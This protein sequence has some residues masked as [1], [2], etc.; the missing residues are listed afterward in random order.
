LHQFKYDQEH[1]MVIRS[2]YQSFLV[3]KSQ[4]A[5]G[6]GIDNPDLPSWMFDYQSS[7]TAWALRMGRAA[8]FADCGMGKTPMQ[9]V[10]ADNVARSTNKPVLIL[11]PIA[12]GAQTIAEA[13]KFGIEA[14]RS[15]GIAHSGINVTNY[16]KLHKFNASDFSGV[17]CDESSILKQ[18]DGAT[19]TRVTE[20]MR[21]LPFRLLCTATAAPND[22]IELGT[23]SEALG[24]LGHI[25]M[26]N[27][28][29]KNARNT[30][31]TKRNWDTGALWRLKA[32]AETPF[33]QW[34]ASWARALRKPSDLGFSD[35]GFDLPPLVEKEHIVASIKP[36]NGMLFALPANG[37]KEQ[38][39]ERRNTIIERCGRAAD[40]INA[41]SEPAVAWC[42]LNDEGDLLEK[43]INGC[44]QISGADSD[45]EKEEKFAAFQSGKVRALVIKPII[46]AWGLNW[47]HCNHMTVF[48]GYS[49]EQY[50][51]GIRRCWR[52]GQKRS[53][54]VDH[55]L[56]DGET[57]VIASRK[58]KSEKTDK[59]FAELVRHM[60]D[61]LAV[62]S[63]R[64]G[65][66]K[67]EVP[68]WL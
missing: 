15:D 52:F 5:G 14:R 66:K 42:N 23:S 12:V 56:S 34:V 50:Y 32:H 53:V 29:F 22:F 41:T 33:W 31:D 47:Q 64:Y 36:R 17:V 38:R 4:V 65:E 9:L 59:M 62:E 40:I 55:V 49:F 58:L 18:F 13:A 60:K 21:T 20:F 61:G 25:D 51:Q 63:A 19:K 45:D 28:F 54:V 10:W 35:E 48:A 7:L 37:L 26:L 16:E 68:S 27:R 43:S 3:S 1:I 8:I 67:E 46:G 39:E 2:D 6:E 24:H 57:D 30:S 11:T 44:V